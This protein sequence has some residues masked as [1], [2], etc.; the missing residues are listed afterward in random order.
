[1]RFTL[2]FPQITLVPSVCL[3]DTQFIRGTVYEIRPTNCNIYSDRANGALI[4]APQPQ[5][6]NVTLHH[7]EREGGRE[8]REDVQF[9]EYKEKVK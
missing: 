5:P 3:G 8:E 2:W 4:L 7:R 1:M 6:I 9:R